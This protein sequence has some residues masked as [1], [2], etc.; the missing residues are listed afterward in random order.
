MPKPNLNPNRT[1]N[2]DPHPQAGSAAG[3]LL[4]DNEQ[5]RVLK[6]YEAFAEP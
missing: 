1:P 3:V 6:G 5:S 2:A 4:K